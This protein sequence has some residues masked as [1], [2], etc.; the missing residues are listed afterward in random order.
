MAKVQIEEYDQSAGVFEFTREVMFWHTLHLADG[1][2]V[3]L[4]KSWDMN[5]PNCIRRAL[6]SLM[7]TC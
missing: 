6:K 4:A 3:V 2:S 7:V 5:W 1:T